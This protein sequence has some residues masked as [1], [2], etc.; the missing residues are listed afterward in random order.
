MATW[1]ARGGR[2]LVLVG[3]DDGEL[4]AL[5][6]LVVVVVDEDAHLARAPHVVRAAQRQEAQPDV[7][8]LAGGDRERGHLECEMARRVEVVLFC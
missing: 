7:A 6:V 5:L 1:T 4:E 8:H 3:V 2:R